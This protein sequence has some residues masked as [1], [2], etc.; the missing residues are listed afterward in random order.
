MAEIIT[1]WG[2][3]G[4]GKSM[5]SCVL[6]RVLTRDKQKAIIINTDSGAPMLPI[7]APGEIVETGSSVGQVLTAVEM[8]TAFVASKVTVP[9][10]YPFI[11]LLGYAAS[12]NPL[13]YPEIKY[14]MALNLI[15]TASKLVDYLILDCSSDMTDIFT[16]AAIES[17]DM[18]VRILTPDLRGINYLK[19]HQPLL[20]DL[21]F[22]YDEHLSFAGL[23]RPFHAIEEMGHIIG[24]WAGLLPYSKEVDRCA[25]EGDMFKAIGFCHPKYIASVKKVLEVMF[26]EESE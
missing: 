4:S 15:S 20:T 13:T 24:G 3:P 23:A 12:E 10:P 9:K 16:P 11:G 6:A 19:A 14:D 2:N 26:L 21:R 17:A 1:V 25:T 22:R 7:W 5:F 18:V 8:D